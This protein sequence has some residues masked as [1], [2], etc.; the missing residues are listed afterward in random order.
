MSSGVPV[1]TDVSDSAV[2]LSLIVRL[3]NRSP[4][5]SPDCVKPSILKVKEI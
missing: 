5:L 4:F 3:W 1:V 2:G